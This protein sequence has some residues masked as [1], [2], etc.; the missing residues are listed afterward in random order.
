MGT[1]HHQLPG[2]QQADGQREGRGYVPV[3]QDKIK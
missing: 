2:A 1:A 3:K